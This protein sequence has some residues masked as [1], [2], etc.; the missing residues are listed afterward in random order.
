MPPLGHEITKQR[1]RSV[2]L[3]GRKIIYRW[4]YDSNSSSTSD[5][6][7][8]SPSPRRWRRVRRCLEWRTYWRAVDRDSRTRS[9]MVSQ[10]TRFKSCEKLLAD[11]RL[12]AERR[13]I[14]STMAP[15]LNVDNTTRG[16]TTSIG[17]HTLS[18]LRGDSIALQ[19]W[20]G[21]ATTSGKRIGWHTAATRP[22]AQPSMD[23][24]RRRWHRCQ[25]R[26]LAPG[27]QADI[28]D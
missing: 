7:L 23:D 19:T 20:R 9:E 14:S 4:S 6:G 2:L 5:G 1:P 10:R 24:S 22:C 16:G 17:S 13:F 12:I 15:L 21:S 11:L 27:F 3:I 25:G 18:G 26:Y 28:Q 8:L